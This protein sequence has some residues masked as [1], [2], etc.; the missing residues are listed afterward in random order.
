VIF[1]SSKAHE[2]N[3]LFVVVPRLRV[4]VVV[5]RLRV[6]GAHPLTVPVD[7]LMLKACSH[8]HQLQY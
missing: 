6:G 5:P 7:A 4:F 1:G 2:L 3:A 8:S